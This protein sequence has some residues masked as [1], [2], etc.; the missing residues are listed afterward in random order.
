M[1]LLSKTCFDLSSELAKLQQD[2]CIYIAESVDCQLTIN[3]DTFVL[4]PCL[5]SHVDIQQELCDNVNR[6]VSQSKS[7][8][9]AGESGHLEF[10]VIPC[11]GDN[12]DNIIFMFETTADKGQVKINY[13]WAL[14]EVIV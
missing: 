8:T 2:E 6:I 4:K 3:I 10:Y 9:F 14:V 1:L 12:N 5:M 11:G 7:F 13:Y